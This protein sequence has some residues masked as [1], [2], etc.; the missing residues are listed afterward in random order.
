MGVGFRQLVIIL[1][2]SLRAKSHYLV[3]A[4]LCH[5]ALVYS[6]VEQHRDRAAVLF[7]C[8]CA[9]QSDSASFPSMLI[10]VTTICLV[11]RQCVL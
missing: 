2:D 1:H 6:A 4:N 8:R 11:F 7:V 9:P 5:T 3:C 10:M